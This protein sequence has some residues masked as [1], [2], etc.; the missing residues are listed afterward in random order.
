MCQ[1]QHHTNPK[2]LLGLFIRTLPFIESLVIVVLLMAIH[3]P[4]AIF[5]QERSWFYL[6]QI[7]TCYSVWRGGLFP[8]LFSLAAS[9]FA[10]VFYYLPPK[11]SIAVESQADV[12]SLLIYVIVG[13]VIVAFGA[14]HHTQRQKAMFRERELTTANLNLAQT[15]VQ[16][17]HVLQQHTQALQ[18]LRILSSDERRN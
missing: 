13:L 12:I 10:A 4:F 17:Y 16:L 2:R 14:V 11:F 3:G 15:N 8:G 5:I 9:T 6:L 18:D 1:Y 7:G